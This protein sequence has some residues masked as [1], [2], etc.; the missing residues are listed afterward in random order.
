MQNALGPLI[1]SVPLSISLSGCI[2][3][4]YIFVSQLSMPLAS[5]PLVQLSNSSSYDCFN[6]QHNSTPAQINRSS[7][8]QE[9]HLLFLLSPV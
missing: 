1:A 8:S 2:Y 9:L 5:H 4:A 6:L 3:L 7:F